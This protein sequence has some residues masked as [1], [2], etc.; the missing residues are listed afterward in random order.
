MGF[1]EKNTFHP[2]IYKKVLD[3]TNKTITD[4]ISR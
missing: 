4:F 3:E 2:K 1:I